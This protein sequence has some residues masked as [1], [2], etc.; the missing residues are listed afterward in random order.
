MNVFSRIKE[1]SYQDS[2]KL[3]RI[4]GEIQEM[5]QVLE[6]FAFMGSE[7]NKKTRIPDALQTDEIRS[8]GPDDL[9]LMVKSNNQQAAQEALAAFDRKLSETVQEDETREHRPATFEEGIK[10]LPGANLALVSVPG[11]YAAYQAQRALQLGLN[12]M[13][14]SDNVPLEDEIALKDVALDKGLLMMGPDC[15]TAILN[16]V[17]LCFANA[18]SRGGI[19]VVGASGTGMQ[20]VTSLVDLL[21]EGISQAIGVGGRDLSSQVNARMSVFAIQQ[22]AQDPQTKV[23]V[24]V[25]KPPAETAAKLVLDA[26][27]QAGKPAVLVFIGSKAAMSEGNIH[28]AGSL[29]Q[30]AAMAVALARGQD[31]N[32]AQHAFER[33]ELPEE[34]N[35]RVSQLRGKQRYVRGLFTGGTLAGEAAWQLHKVLGDLVTNTGIAGTTKWTG[36]QNPASHLVLDLGDDAFTQGALHPMIDPTGRSRHIRQAMR[37][38]QSAIILCDLVIG[39]GSHENPAGVLAKAVMEAKEGLDHSPLVLASVTGTQKDGQGRSRQSAILK[40]AGIH[41]FET[42]QYAVEACVQLIRQLENGGMHE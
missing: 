14:F 25:S 5:P 3:M 12:V 19:G 27:A 42:N 22:L 9:I 2:L 31:P 10:A 36:Q 35:S 28:Y 13:M 29:E 38:E 16:G 32:R 6:A 4:S 30:S 17:P 37:D 20:E 23:I 41:V 21:G 39:A 18:V 26:L 7:I 33:K 24:V 11:E 8:A 15:G 1:R 40:E 34:L